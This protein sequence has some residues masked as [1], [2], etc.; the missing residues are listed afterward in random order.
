MCC[1]GLVEKNCTC[2]IK[3]TYL[4]IEDAD[5]VAEIIKDHY[6][7]SYSISTSIDIRKEQ[8]TN[9]KIHSIYLYP[10]KSCAPMKVSRWPLDSSSLLYDR[11]F[12][13][14][15]G[16]KPLTQKMLPMLCMIRPI[17]DLE[18]RVMTIS[19]PGEKDHVLNLKKGSSRNIERTFK[20]TCVGKVCGDEVEGLDCGQ[21]VSNWLESVTGL[22]NL[23][24]VQLT[25]REQRKSVKSYKQTQDLRSFANEAQ[26]LI[27]NLNSVR[28][29]DKML[30]LGESNEDNGN[31]VASKIEW[32]T[33]QF[34]G[35]I[36]MSGNLASF[37]E[38]HWRC[39]RVRNEHSGCVAR[40][41]IQNLCK[42]C[43]VLSVD[44]KNGELT[45]EPL[46]TLSKMEG[47]K[48]SFGVLASLECDK[49]F[50]LNNSYISTHWQLEISCHK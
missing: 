6:L 9:A 43:S 13:I 37:E 1:Y 23:T 44:Q 3:F 48:F 30:S 18:L 10:I 26:F 14:M 42:R 31:S 17:I 24:L 19:Y 29:L 50:D 27:L 33:E 15:Q 38:E 46:K 5:R 36:V 12:V 47:R 35:N 2:E 22:S 39:I 21:D 16:R 40:F 34:R 32:I 25:K 11:S 4:I 7:H 41:N 8:F 45:Q 49:D 20:K 28:E